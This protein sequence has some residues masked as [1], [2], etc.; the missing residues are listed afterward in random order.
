MLVR[1]LGEFPPFGPPTA[2]RLLTLLG[3]EKDYFLRGRRAEAQGMGIGAFA[4]YRRV[5]ENKKTAIFE[6]I[7][8]VARALPDPDQ[9]LLTELE[10][11]KLETQFDKAVQSI[12]HAIPTSL[13]VDGHN[14]LKLLHAALSEGLHADSDELCL[15][16]AE[17]IRLV[18][19][20]FVERVELALKN[21]AS[22]RAAV[23]R[24]TAAKKAK[25]SST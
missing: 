5:V 4:Y 1:K 12:R 10:N 24:L 14:P 18:L 25:A 6:Q 19:S 11:A 7:I 16:S 13:L 3:G 8:R 17:G 22:L 15:E 23:G 20:D 2:T 9:D 21:D